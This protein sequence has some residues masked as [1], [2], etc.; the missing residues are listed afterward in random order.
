M[1]ISLKVETE[2]TGTFESLFEKADRE[3]LA[4]KA[5]KFLKGRTPTQYI[6]DLR[7]ELSEKYTLDELIEWCNSP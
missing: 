3:K 4:E 7:K 5:E 1:A 2:K 6:K